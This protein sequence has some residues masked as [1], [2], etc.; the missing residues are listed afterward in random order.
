MLTSHPFKV[1]LSLSGGGYRATAFH[2]GTLKKLNDMDL[3]PKVDIVS[4]ISGGSITGASYALKKGTF[5]QFYNELYEGLQEKNVIRELLLSHI[6]VRFLGYFLLLIGAGYFLFTPYAWLF[7]VLVAIW[8]IVLFKFQFVLFPISQEIEKIYDRFFYNQAKLE[9]LAEKPV[10]VIGSTNLQT[11]R[12][13]IFSRN[14]MQ[15][16]TYQYMSPK[17]TFEAAGFPVSRAVMASSCVPFAFT[18]ISI[19]KEYF[20]PGSDSSKVHPSLVD[21]G[22]YDNQ[23]IHR[24]VQHGRYACETVITSDAGAGFYGK[25]RYTNTIELLLETVNVFM[26]RI[27]NA[28]LAQ[29]VFNNAGTANKQI[30]YIS[31]GWDVENCIP[32]FIRNLAD[33]QITESVILRHQL[34]PEWVANPKEYEAVIK[35]YL[36]ERLQYDRI[37][38]PSVG[39]KKIARTV[40]TNLTALSKKQVDCLISQAEALTELQVKLYCPGLF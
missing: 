29:D 7:P 23:G 4:T 27:K 16:S 17:I 8:I 3:L 9:Q 22:I 10:L 1:G 15:D 14:W 36:E 24:I 34:K 2:L 6:G 21:G 37:V 5:Y 26:A 25:G 38:K 32:G 30:A 13:F 31:L 11:A 20:S 33:G 19:A 12:P 39:D 40:G 35:A 28:Q 18:P